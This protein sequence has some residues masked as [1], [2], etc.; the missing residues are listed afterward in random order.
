MNRRIEIRPPVDARRDPVDIV[1]RHELRQVD[2]A[3]GHPQA[4]GEH[5]LR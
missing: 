4:G 5:I 1:H 3:Y 2:S